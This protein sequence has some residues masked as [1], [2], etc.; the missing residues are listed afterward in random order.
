MFDFMKRVFRANRT[1]NKRIVTDYRIVRSVRDEDVLPDGSRVIY[2]ESPKELILYKK[3]PG[4]K[5][6]VY[7]F[8][9]NTGMIYLDGTK[10]NVSEKKNESSKTSKKESKKS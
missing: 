10:A 7:T 2:A 8:N 4:E 3:C 5:A 9:R 6:T 1:S